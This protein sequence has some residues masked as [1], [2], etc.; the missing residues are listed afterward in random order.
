MWYA[1]LFTMSF[2]PV[3]EVD[4]RRDRAS[5]PP[6]WGR[7]RPVTVDFGQKLAICDLTFGGALHSCS[8]SSA[9]EPGEGHMGNVG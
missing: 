2:F 8:E 7:T 5:R 3:E 6:S 9:V 4:R 1:A